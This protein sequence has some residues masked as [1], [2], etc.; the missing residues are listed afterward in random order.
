MSV[1]EQFGTDILLTCRGHSRFGKLPEQTLESLIVSVA[2]VRRRR[3]STRLAWRQ[4]TSTLSSSVSS[5]SVSVR[6]H[7][8]HLWLFR[9][10]SISSEPG[11][12][13]EERLRT[14]GSG[15]APVGL[16]FSLHADHIWH[17][18]TTNRSPL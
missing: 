11:N 15:D 18:Y 17:C 14:W 3:R 4:L 6:S 1:K 2:S 10:L 7:L 13:R 12:A 5:T 8:S 16:T 9:P